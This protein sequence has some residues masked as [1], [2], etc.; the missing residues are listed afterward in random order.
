MAAHIARDLADALEQPRIVEGGFTGGD[1]V[2]WELSRFPHQPRGVRQSAD[3]DRP[4]VGGHPSER[5]AR[6]QHGS[7][8]EAC[9]AERR[10][11]AG[12]PGTDHEHVDVG[13]AHAGLCPAL[14]ITE[15]NH[16]L[17][18]VGLALERLLERVRTDPYGSR[19]VQATTC[20]LWPAPARRDS[21]GDGW[22]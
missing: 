11:N 17:D 7:G 20:P 22:R 9:R 6:D 4:V 14:L 18:V 16:D 15:L 2:A 5:I 1:A 12:G 19:A 21:S 3:G 10:E 13:V 8:S